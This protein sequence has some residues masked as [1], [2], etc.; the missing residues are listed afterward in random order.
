MERL[1]GR[2]LLMAACV[3]AL[4][5]PIACDDEVTDSGAAGQDSGVDGAEADAGPDVGGADADGAEP[6]I[7]A[8]GMEEG[9]AMGRACA[10]F[11]PS[12]VSAG[13][14]LGSIL[15]LA[16][17]D[18]DSRPDAV[19]NHYLATPGGLVAGRI[20]FYAGRGDGTFAAATPIEPGGG[21]VEMVA[22][23]FDGDGVADLAVGV[24]SGIQSEH[25]RLLLIRGQCEKGPGIAEVIFEPDPYRGTDK[26]V[27][28][29]NGDGADDLIVSQAGRHNRVEVLFGGAAPFTTSAASEDLPDGI[30]QV[31][32]ADINGDGE[33]E[34]IAA[35]ESQWAVLSQNEAG[36]LMIVGVSAVEAKG[37]IGLEAMDLDSDGID[38]LV[39]LRVG[40]TDFVDAYRYVP[41]DGRFKRETLLNAPGLLQVVAADITGDG[42]QDLAVVALNRTELLIQGRLGL[43]GAGIPSTEG[44]L[45]I[46]DVTGDG[47]ADLVFG[48]REGLKVFPNQ[49]EACERRLP[50][51]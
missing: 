20:D 8:D 22:G 37:I 48:S 33:R 6:E 23:D 15:R 17:F 31:A 32:I 21:P 9:G 49:P 11:G 3:T 34:V 44:T 10:P 5:L 19:R 43:M 1:R 40:S 24:V 47:Y 28:D 27:A 12:V 13:Q 14:A 39:A 46:G 41:G 51:W 4:A 16:D 18:C 30:S 29:M 25:S 45:A 36:A 50:R 7:G 2:G 26:V 38:E 35:G 42:R